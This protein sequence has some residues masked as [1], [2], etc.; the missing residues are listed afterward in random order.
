MRTLIPHG[1][2]ILLLGA[3]SSLMQAL[4][5]QLAAAGHPLV[6]AGRD[7]T[8]LETLAA[9][10]ATRYGT[11]CQLCVVDVAEPGFNAQQAIAAAGA[12]QHAVIAIGD[13]G[14]GNPDDAG[15]MQQLAQLNY[16]APAMLA[17]AAAAQLAEAGRG[18]VAVVSSVAGDRGRASNYGYGSAKAA[19]TTYVSG[20]RARY[21]RQGVHVLTIKPGFIDTP[22]TWG[23]QSPLMATREKVAAD[24]IRAMRRGHDVTYSPWFWRL[25]M[26]IIQHLPERVFKKLRF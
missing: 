17:A 13:M 18:V 7:E 5:R 11:T 10:L 21:A 22:M 24:I 14:T 23:M 19:L 2:N 25:I 9:D 4:A 20:L 16:L 1:D 8:E 3:T 15:G 6:L 26:G 12:F